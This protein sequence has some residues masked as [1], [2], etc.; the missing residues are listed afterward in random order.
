MNSVAK[1]F[2][3]SYQVLT[4]EQILHHKGLN[5]HVLTQRRLVTEDSFLIGLLLLLNFSYRQQK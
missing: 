5:Q 1:L 3:Y 2:R 4:C